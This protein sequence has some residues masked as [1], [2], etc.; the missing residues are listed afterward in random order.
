ML[1]NDLIKELSDEELESCVG[2]TG[3]INSAGNKVEFGWTEQSGLIATV[4]GTASSTVLSTTAIGSFTTFVTVVSDLTFDPDGS[5]RFRCDRQ[6]K[7]NVEAVDVQ[8]IL[9][10]VAELPITTWNYKDEAAAVRHIGPMAQDFAAAFS[11]GDND[12]SIHA[13]DLHGV[14]IAAIQ[15]I[16]SQLQQRDAEVEKLRAELQTLKQQLEPA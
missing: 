8:D 12:T 15:A 7:E 2:G 11:V 9:Q 1:S 14:T 3:L 10:R 5:A 16:Y 13:V 4:L 6:V